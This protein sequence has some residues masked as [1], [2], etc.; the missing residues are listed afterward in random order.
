MLTLKYIFLLNH[1]FL[2]FKKMA[3]FNFPSFII[4]LILGMIVMLTL[5]WIAYFTRT[6][7]FINCPG[8]ARVCTGED[9]YNDPGEAI[10][11]TGVTAGQ[12]LFIDNGR[13]YYKRVPKNG[14]CIP[15]GN[16]TV[17]IAYPQYCKFSGSGISGVTGR[18]LYFN[19]NLYR[20]QHGGLTQPIITDENCD[21][22][23]GQTVTEGEPILYWT[24]THVPEPTP[25]YG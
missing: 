13:M 16:Q 11:K 23:S 18:D 15:E 7:A 22:R 6:G 10:A 1:L 9:Y 12:I 3:V 4:G 17:R 2:V 8:Q 21:P 14:T 24:P 20:L 5:I 25:Q 19:A